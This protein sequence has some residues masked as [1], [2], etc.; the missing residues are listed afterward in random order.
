MG[1]ENH[2]VVKAFMSLNVVPMADLQRILKPGPLLTEMVS[3]LIKA[4]LEQI[5]NYDTFR[6]KKI[7]R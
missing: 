5:A 1:K 2:G 4:P 3:P 6:K 7:V